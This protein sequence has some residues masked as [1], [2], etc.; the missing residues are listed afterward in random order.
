MLIVLLFDAEGTEQKESRRVH[1]FYPQ[2]DTHA[3]VIPTLIRDL[4]IVTGIIL[5]IGNLQPAKKVRDIFIFDMPYL[6][7][8]TASSLCTEI[9]SVMRGA[10]HTRERPDILDHCNSEE[11]DGQSISPYTADLSAL[12]LLCGDV[13][14]NPGPTTTGEKP[15][16]QSQQTEEVSTCDL[17][18]HKCCLFEYPGVCNLIRDSCIAKLIDHVLLGPFN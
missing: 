10:M 11:R 12:L 14:S 13:E 3:E 1:F 4:D 6:E 2:L 8:C 15:H 16:P 18:L 9:T 17:H 5:H 7:V